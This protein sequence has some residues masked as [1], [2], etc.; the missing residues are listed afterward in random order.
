VV[1]PKA[2]AIPH[3][4]LDCADEVIEYQEETAPARGRSTEAVWGL[5]GNRRMALRLPLQPTT[6]KSGAL[7]T[8]AHSPGF[9]LRVSGRHRAVGTGLFPTTVA[10]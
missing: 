8:F 7:L 10:V 5:V 9:K 4:L 1:W 6:S 3:S 2:I